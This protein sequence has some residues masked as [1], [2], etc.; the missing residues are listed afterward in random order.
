MHLK[1]LEENKMGNLPLY[2]DLKDMQKRSTAL[3]GNEM[4]EAVA[5]LS[6]AYEL[7]G[8]ERTKT[9]KEAQTKMH[10]ILL[11]ILAERERLR[12]RRQLAELVERVRS[13]IGSQK[14]LLQ[15]TLQL[16]D[17]NETATAG[18]IHSQKALGVMSISLAKILKS[19]AEQS[20]D[21]GALAGDA[22]RAMQKAGITEAMGKSVKQ[23]TATDFPEAAETQRGIIAGLERVMATLQTSTRDSLVKAREQVVKLLERQETILKAV[24]SQQFTDANADQWVKGQGEITEGLRSIIALIGTSEKCIRLADL[25]VSA[26]ENAR[27]ALFGKEKTQTMDEQGRVVGALAQLLEELDKQ[28]GMERARTAE[29]L[30]ALHKKL[31]EITAK[32][33]AALQKHDQGAKIAAGDTPKASGIEVEVGKVLKAVA[34][35]QGLTRIV[36]SRMLTAADAAEAAGEALARK[37]PES[38]KKV[39]TAGRAIRH[40]H[41]EAREG[42]SWAII[43]ALVMT[44]SELNRANEVLDRAAAACMYISG[45][46]KAGEVTAEQLE[47]ARSETEK[48]RQISEKIAEGV[49]VTAP[50]AIKPLNTAATEAAKLVREMGK[51]KKDAAV[52]EQIAK[53]I[54]VASAGVR[55]VMGGTATKLIEVVKIEL[56]GVVALQEEINKLLGG[57]EQP[58]AAQIHTL[59]DKAFGNTPSVGAALHRAADIHP[60]GER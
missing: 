54:N 46:L 44:L 35:E 30:M 53:N 6:K 37:S 34:S 47:Y 9:Y 60:K 21:H 27:R 50:D 41:G 17:D 38:A 12:V 23:L 33:A 43:D 10:Q 24:R 55:K 29:E 57:T 32:I 42:A 22:Q 28:I 15:K 49:A 58:P 18:A 19:A 13:L 39:Q 2:N 52:A 7:Q 8:P 26:S 56:T 4:K 16:N 31:L 40:A 14:S 3:I 59:G 48:V 36:V 5:L 1:Q 11:R 51:K 25:G 45:E 20:G